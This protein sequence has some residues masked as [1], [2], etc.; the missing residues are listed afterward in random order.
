MKQSKIF[1][2][3][4]LLFSTLLFSQNKL[5]KD[6]INDIVD[7]MTLEEKIFMVLGNNNNEWRKYIGVGSTW[8]SSEHG[9]PPIIFDDGPAGLRIKPH[10]EGDTKTYFCTA[11]PTA[12]A[13][14][15]TWN[16][17]LV[18]NV[19]KA[20]GNEVLEYGSDIL[21][22]PA[23]NIHRNPLNGR[24]FEYYSEDPLLSGKIGASMVRGVQS[25]GVGT[26]VKHFIANNQ[27][28]NRKGVNTVISQRALREIYLRSFEIIV[29]ESHPWTIMSSYNRI[30]GIYAAE[31]KDLL[32]RV[33]R[34]EWGFKGIILSDWV[35][36]NDAVAQIRAGNDLIMP[37]F[38]V[39]YA[40]YHYDEL[41]SAVKDKIL[42]EET[43]NQCVR[44][45]L[46]TVTMTPRFKN[47]KF[48]ST[49]DLK[50]HAQISLEAASEA[51]VL[52]KNDNGTLPLK[53]S[54]KNIALFGKTSY[55]FIAGGTGSG[56]VNYERA[57]SLKEGLT[58]GGFKLL[59]PIEDFYTIIVD[60]IYA[61]T[62]GNNKYA[63]VNHAEITISK[64]EIKKQLKKSDAA[65]ITIGR[66]S[67]EGADRSEKDYFG[68]T[69]VERQL[70]S[71]VCDVY[72]AVGKKVIVV[73]NIGGVIETNSWKD[74]PD[75]ILLAWQTGQQ[76]GEAVNDILTGKANPSGKLPMS[77]PLTYA[78][79][80]S[81]PFFPGVPEKNPIN[82]F[83]NEGIYVGYR[84]Y[85]TFDKAVSY[86]FGYGLSF[87][88][89]E[90]SDIKISSEIFENNVTVNLRI[91]NAGKVSGKEVVQLYLSAPDENIDKPTKELKGIVKTKMLLPGESQDVSF[92]IDA[93]SLASF[94]SGISCWVVDQGK[95]EVLVGS[96]SRD[97][98]QKVYFNVPSV[99]E[100]EQLNDVMYPN[101][102]IKDMGTESEIEL[103]NRSPFNRHQRLFYDFLWYKKI[104]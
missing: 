47:Y 99:I 86:E 24:N 60:S 45:I 93:R 65:I 18:E 102:V 41:L 2:L 17:E 66:I 64:E 6:N 34:D 85:D 13:L 40:Q 48:S 8:M 53:K 44:R 22:A 92:V 78:D 88:T 9:I 1:T 101:F 76:G 79:V 28:S 21:L 3:S 29:K 56:E 50:S 4:F 49:P 37:G 77:Y 91:K 74:L 20:M 59:K 52:L 80:P 84:F 7:R 71:D 32:K 10:R 27:E 98:R 23:A 69:D 30:N 38:P 51:M 70:I 81:S 103:N 89:F 14:A 11:F 57:V 54:I 67:G 36:G 63:V 58:K 12:T 95:Y 19:G 75:A 43:L 62:K 83:Y 39:E 31:N 25:N 68:L 26:S 5:N 16:T 15:A 82:S 33:L 55:D 97:I 73:L 94:W 100:T 46:N 96:S 72:H 61:N 104:K 35:S 42:D 87:T 90:Y